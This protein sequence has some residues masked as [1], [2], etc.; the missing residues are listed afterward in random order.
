MLI[1]GGWYHYRKVVPEGLRRAVGK[2]EFK[3]SLDTRDPD[4]ARARWATVS[5]RVEAELNLLRRQ[6]R[7]EDFDRSPLTQ[8]EIRAYAGEFY[9]ELVAKYEENPGDP[10]TWE[11][12]LASN[13]LSV[14]EEER[15]QFAP[16]RRL[17]TGWGSHHSHVAARRYAG[18][19]QKFLVRRLRAPDVRSRLNLASAVALAVQ[20]A[21]LQLHRNSQGDYTEDAVARSFPPPILPKLPPYTVDNLMDG[22]MSEGGAR[23]A[24]D[25]RWRSIMRR[26]TEF[27]QKPDL[28][29]ID[30]ND[31]VRWKEH[32]LSMGIAPQTIRDADLAA[33]RVLFNWAVGAKK[34]RAN[35]ALSV[36]I[37]VPTKQAERLEKGFTEEEAEQILRASLVP[38]SRRLTAEGAAA[39]RWLPWLCA[40]TG[41]RVN[42]LSYL[43]ADGIQLRQKK[44]M[45]DVHIIWIPAEVSKT[46]QARQAPIHP[47]LIEM[48]FLKYVQSRKG[49]PLFFDVSRGR[50]SNNKFSQSHKV[51]QRVADWVRGEVGITDPEL[52]PNHAWRH[53]FRT[54]CRSADLEE[55]RID[56][57]DGHASTVGQ[58]YGDSL[59]W[60]MLDWVSRLPRYEIETPSR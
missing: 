44:G 58:K 45:P 40:Y 42:E 53:R 57:L 15:S 20:H 11:K 52:L 60:V 41:A 19:L 32:R 50:G 38:S 22:Y 35:P 47:H 54:M 14:P 3:E 29:D 48:G 13:D 24:T 27:L 17:M 1:R 36:K 5:A 51:A 18:D 23:E 7:E 25:K 9:R 10:S 16:T 34:M 33:P 46:K 31:M 6:G 28:N 43:A 8:R 37:R 26:L 59:P 30:E 39:R 49:R 21:Q 56:L 12:L 4:I 55:A 2:R